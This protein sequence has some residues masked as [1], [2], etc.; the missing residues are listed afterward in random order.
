[1]QEWSL[2]GVVQIY[3]SAAFHRVSNSGLL[4]KLKSIGV[5][6]SVLSTCTEFL[7]NRWQRVVVDGAAREWIPI[8]S[9]VPQGSVLGP[10]LFI[11]FTSKMFELVENRLYAYADDS[12]LLAVVRKQPDRPPVAA[13]FNRDLARIQKLCNHC[14]MILN[15]NKNKASVVS[16]SQTVSPPH[17]DLILAGVSIRASPNLDIL[18]VKFDSKLAFEDHVRG[19]I[20][21]R[22]SQRIDILRLVK[23]IFVDT[24]SYFVAI[25]NLF[26][27][28]LRGS[29]RRCGGQLLN[30]TFSFLSAR[31]IRWPGFVPIKVSCRYVIDVVWLGLVCC[32]RLIR[33]V[34]TVC[35]ASFHLLQLEYDNPSCGSSTSIGVWSIKV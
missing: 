10:L 25:L 8:F 31:C 5:G 34:I 21:Y 20:V 32:T 15:P 1:M 14:Y 13:L 9:G 28:Y 22:V 35:S 12:T 33:T 3:F 26:F 11:L 19:I 6:G 27:Q 18:G 7:S 17:V 24:L 29:I 2:S 30:V 4:F 23:R 16:R